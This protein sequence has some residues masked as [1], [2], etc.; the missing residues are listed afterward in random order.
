MDELLNMTKTLARN[1]VAA[2]D[3]YGAVNPVRAYTRYAYW[4]R[5]E[6]A[7]ISVEGPLTGVSTAV[8]PDTERLVGK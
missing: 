3:P 5:G 8:V 1:A 4:S 6:R 7:R 2:D